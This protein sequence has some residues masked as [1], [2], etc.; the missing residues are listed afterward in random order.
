M[1]PHNHLLAVSHFDIVG[2]ALDVVGRRGETQR[3][4]KG[5]RVVVILDVSNAFY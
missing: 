5:G 4:L 3:V 2:V 1:I